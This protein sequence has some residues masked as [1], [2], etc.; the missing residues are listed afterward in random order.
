M[1][2]PEDD[3]HNGWVFT[4]CYILVFLSAPVLYIG[5]V[6]ATLLDKLGASATLASLPASAYMF[7][8]ISPL[9]FAWLVPHRLER[10]AAVWGNFATAVVIGLVFMALAL[11]TSREFRIGAVVIQGLL[12]GL[13]HSVAFVFMLQCLRRGTTE[14]GLARALKR[15]FGAT[16]LVAVA[17]SLGAQYILNPGLPFLPYPYD[18]AALHLIATACVIGIALMVRSFR[19]TPIEEEPRPALLSYL[20]SSI[21]SFVADRRMVLLWFAY[22]LWY[23]SLGITGNL[24]LFTRQAMGR[25]PKDFSG[26]IMAIRFGCKSIGGFFLGAIAVRRGIRAGVLGTTA[27]L[28][29]G[30][31][32]AWLVPGAGYLFAF[33]LLGAGELGGAYFPNYVSTLSAAV[34][35]TRNLSIITM[36]TPASSFSPVLHG[37][38]TD[39]YGFA[40][41][42][43]FSIL[44]ALGALLLVLWAGGK[45]S[46][47]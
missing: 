5:V 6:Q 29:A 1:V 37:A 14:Q 25:E 18:F 43:A 45:K 23:A 22:V 17:G 9:F 4:I 21:R 47:D 44:S 19:L 13:S 15:T 10:S 7:G 26:L 40:A 33:G 31:A 28:A 46:G 30:S 27:L 2:P 32:W 34:Q 42:F 39:R 38:L 12:Q 36:A 24:S 8:Q 20:A 41:S 3:R 16:P 11:P 35:S